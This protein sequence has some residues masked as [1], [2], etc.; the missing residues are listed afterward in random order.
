MVFQMQVYM[1]LQV[2]IGSK[3]LVIYHCLPTF[4]ALPCAGEPLS[5]N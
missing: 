5:D 1:V 3:I 4:K 2:G